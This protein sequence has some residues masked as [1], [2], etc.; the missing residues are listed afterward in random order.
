MMLGT[1]LACHT[2][3]TKIVAHRGASYDAPEN[4]LSAF[5]L[6]WQQQADAIEGD[7]FLTKDSAIVCIHDKTTGRLAG[8]DLIVAE[9]TLDELKQLDVGSWKGSVWAGEK[10]PTIG[11]VLE[12]VPEDKKIFIEIKS[13]PEIV[14]ILKK[15]LSNS[16]LLPEQMVI[17][18]FNSKVIALVKEKIPAVKAYWLTGFRKNKSSDTWEPAL[19]DI[20]TILKEIRAD[21]LDCLAHEVV[22]ESFAKALGSEGME[23]HVWTV[24][25]PDEAQR[26]KKIGVESITT[27]RPGWLRN[28]LQ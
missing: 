14:P 24:D 10:I 13:G 11:Q 17:I 6:A 8:Q 5:K 25:D 19:P 3:D 4:T 12:T 16:S 27:N 20:L 23:L 21:G 22:N 1:I 2:V 15:S 26:L 9:S 28:Q 18:S 7:F